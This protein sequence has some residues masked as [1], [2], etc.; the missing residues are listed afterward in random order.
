MSDLH[1]PL[2]PEGPSS[3]GR[4]TLSPRERAVVVARIRALMEYWQITVE[5]LDASPTE[6]VPAASPAPSRPVKYRHPLSGQA[7]D[8]CGPH[9][10]WLRE[11]LL[12]QGYRV[13]ELRPTVG[14]Q[15]G[16]TAQ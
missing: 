10:D 12:H 15:T 6:G 16:D 7:W 2:T 9:P 3:E 1:T 13:E 8:G 4:P 5:D 14:P 11:A